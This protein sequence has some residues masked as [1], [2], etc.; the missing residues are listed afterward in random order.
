MSIKENERKIA[1]LSEALKK[2]V[3]RRK[4]VGKSSNIYRNS[5]SKIDNSKNDDGNN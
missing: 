2:N 5:E 1:R 4:N 3:K